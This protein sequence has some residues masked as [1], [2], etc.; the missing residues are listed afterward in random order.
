MLLWYEENK[1]L[2][3]E[4]LNFTFHGKHQLETDITAR[5][6]FLECERETRILAPKREVPPGNR[7]IL[8]WRW[9]VHQLAGR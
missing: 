2:A 4:V 6:V 7:S 5:V 9:A 8:F 1:F 3:S